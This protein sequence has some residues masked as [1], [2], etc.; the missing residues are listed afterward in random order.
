MTRCLITGFEPSYGIK[1]TPS[2]ELAKI[3]RDGVVSVNGVETRAMVLPQIF[4]VSAEMTIAEIISFKPHAVIMY[5]ATPRNN[6]IRFERFA[7]NIKNTTSGDNN[8]IPIRDT[9]ILNDGPPAYEASWPCGYLVDKMNNL[10]T[11]SMISYHAGEHTCN[12]LFY[13]VMHWLGVNN[14]QNTI[15][16]GFIHCS[17]P[18]EFGVVEDQDFKTEGFTGLVKASINLVSILHQYHQSKAKTSLPP[19]V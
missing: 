9:K 17:F 2:G 4:D 19:A 6:P 1:K 10:G 5:G 13:Q 15:M 7:V 3:W 16:A 12:A 8:R 11:S 18:D 14:L